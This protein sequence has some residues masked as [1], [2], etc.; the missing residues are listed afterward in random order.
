MSWLE[1]LKTVG[2]LALSAIQ[3]FA[4]LLYMLSIPL[5]WPLYY[6]YAS[7]VFLLSPIWVIASLGLRTAS[8]AINLVA[9]LKYLYV[10]LAC[11]VFIGACVGFLLYGASNF[12]FVLLGW[13]AASE[14]QS[15]LVREQV[16][17]N[18]YDNESS[19]SVERQRSDKGGGLVDINP[20]DLFEKQWKLVRTPVQPRRRRKGLLGQTIMEESSESELS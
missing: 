11:A 19:S 5:R 20:N 6:V 4:H 7:I 2:A 10:Y 12:M 9:R 18:E 17:E 1:T 14:R 8:F 15:F 3:F 13:D 16:K